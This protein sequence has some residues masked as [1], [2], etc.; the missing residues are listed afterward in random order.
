MR[1]RC[2]KVARR[3]K[4][5]YPSTRI[6]VSAI[7]HPSKR[8]QVA[9]AVPHV[10]TEITILA[11]DHVYWPSTEF[12]TSVLA[13]FEDNNMGV[14]ATYKRVIR[15][16]PGKWSAISIVNLIGCFYLLRHNW[17]LRASNAID[18]GVFVVSGRTAAYRTKLLKSPGFMDRFC[19]ERFF[20]GLFGGKG[21]GPDD[22]NFLTREAYRHGW[23]IKFQQTEDSVVETSLGDENAVKFRGQ[24]VRW[25]RTT[26]RSNP[27]MLRQISDVYTWRMPYTYIA[28]YAASLFNFALFW[29]TTL[30]VSLYL[31]WHTRGL[32]TSEMGL[33][34]LWVLWTKTIKL[35][36]HILRHPSDIP[37][38]PCQILFAYAHSI[39]KVW[40]IF[41]FWDCAWLGRNLDAVDAESKE[42]K[43]ELD[44][45]FTYA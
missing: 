27:C 36:P 41:T 23:K 38:I 16:T 13:P 5:Q 28:V 4:E 9:H 42:L 39:I 35:W 2:E 6:G 11:D 3:Y 37:L 31:S 33:L 20:F 18:G 15:T 8:R 19:R 7:L 12:I 21:L 14:V 30:F 34:A 25:A 1:R 43:K 17:E 10:D 29:D 44:K 40:A 22:D 45:D 24:L 32:F 26:F